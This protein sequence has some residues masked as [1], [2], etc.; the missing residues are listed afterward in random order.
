M[1]I[2]L[3]LSTLNGANMWHDLQ[4][5][6]GCL[7]N[8][9]VVWYGVAAHG[10]TVTVQQMLGYL[11]SLAGFALYSWLK[12]RGSRE[13]RRQHGGPGVHATLTHPNPSLLRKAV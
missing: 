6:A 13:S 5:V 12:S 1:F 8:V 2:M 3:L 4:Q 11:V 10:E 9:A 7:K